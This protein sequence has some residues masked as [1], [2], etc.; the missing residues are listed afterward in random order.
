MFDI[1]EIKSWNEA[2]D[3]EFQW[4]GEYTFFDQANGKNISEKTMVLQMEAI[5]SSLKQSFSE[6]NIQNF[7]ISKI[8]ECVLDNFLKGKSPKE[9]FPVLIIMIEKGFSFNTAEEIFIK[10][11]SDTE[12]ITGNNE[13]VKQVDPSKKWSNV[14][15]LGESKMVLEGTIWKHTY[16]QEYDGFIFGAMSTF[17]FKDKGKLIRNSTTLSSSSEFKA[18][19]TTYIDT[20]SRDGDIVKAIFGNGAT[21][22]EGK[23]ES[24]NQKII[25]TSYFS[26][27]KSSEETW[28]PYKEGDQEKFIQLLKSAKKN[29][30]KTTYHDAQ[31]TLYND[32]TPPSKF[33][34]VLGIGLLAG[35]FIS[36]FY[37]FSRGDYND[38]RN[39]IISFI[40]M[41]CSIPFFA[42]YSSEKSKFF[43]KAV[44]ADMAQWV[45]HSSNDLIMQWGAPTKT[46]KFPTDKT[47][48]VLEYKDS[49]RN[50][51]GYRY[52]GMY[53]GQAKTTK[54]IKSFFV[55]DGIIINYKYAI[56]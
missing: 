8:V 24:Q 36:C 47:M 10:Y 52:K 27:G 42:K 3:N 41:L 43:Y 18:E 13:I 9:I 2:T 5:Y 19:T 7:G 54:Y 32:L 51:A 22:F 11:N 33:L 1:C 55:K 49:I 17:E 46:Y 25:G 28:E 21:L 14:V 29:E 6:D 53:A 4:K 34:L 44:C 48:T 45:G 50:Y 30:Q 16:V 38:L 39:I 31:D 23:Y 56:T 20:W 15:L 12:K 35:G 26:N 37:L 40:V